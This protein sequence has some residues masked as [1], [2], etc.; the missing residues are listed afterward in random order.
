MNSTHSHT[1]RRNQRLDPRAAARRF[2]VDLLFA[3]LAGVIL[4]L[5]VAA[6]WSDGML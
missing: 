5:T 4:A 6:A 2:W 3:C 1:S